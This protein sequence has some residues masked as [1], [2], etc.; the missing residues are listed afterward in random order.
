MTALLAPGAHLDGLHIKA[1]ALYPAGEAPIIG[2]RPHGQDALGRERGVGGGEALP[3]VEPVV[4]GPGE[5]VGAV[6]DSVT[7]NDLQDGTFFARI[8]VTTP[9]GLE[10]MFEDQRAYFA[11]LQGAPDPDRIR[12]IGARYGVRSLGPP[13]SLE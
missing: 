2:R 10:G 7:I 5:A 12:E 3:G 9:A 6:V 4:C 1:R 13:I 11:G 8:G